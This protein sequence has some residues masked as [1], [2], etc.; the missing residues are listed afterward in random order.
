MLNWGIDLSEISEDLKQIVSSTIESVKEGM[1]GKD[2][3]VVGTIKFELAVVKVREAKGGFKFFI[4]E[5]GG[6]YSS[7]NTS[8]IT[9]E[10]GGNRTTR[11]SSFVGTW[12]TENK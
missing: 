10:V 11:G 9:F 1:K 3:G 4:A 8:K 6:N 2:C 12:L 7:Q 5:A